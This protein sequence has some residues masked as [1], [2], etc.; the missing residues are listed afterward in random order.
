MLVHVLE[1]KPP[2]LTQEKWEVTLDK[3]E[4][5]KVDQ[6]YEFLYKNAVCASRP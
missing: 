5:P 3:D 6:M 2:K 4:F 1:T